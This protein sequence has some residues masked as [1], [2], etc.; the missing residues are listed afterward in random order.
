MLRLV[1]YRCRRHGSSLS[2]NYLRSLK[3]LCDRMCTLAKYRYHF[4]VTTVL[5]KSLLNMR[6]CSRPGFCSQLAAWNTPCVI[7]NKGM[8]SEARPDQEFDKF[9]EVARWKCAPVSK[10]GMLTVSRTHAPNLT[11][12]VASNAEYGQSFSGCGQLTEEQ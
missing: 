12:G 1:V 8:R 9:A 3:S 4:S 10:P 7:G 6:A 2:P 5:P 11:I